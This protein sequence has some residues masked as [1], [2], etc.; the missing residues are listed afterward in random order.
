VSPSAAASPSSEPDD[1]QAS[2]NSG[3]AARANAGRARRTSAASAIA[4]SGGTATSAR[5][6]SASAELSYNAINPITTTMEAGGTSAHQRLLSRPMR[7]RRGSPGRA[8]TA[9]CASVR[10]QMETANDG[11]AHI[12]SGSGPRGR[13]AAS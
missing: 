5:T 13:E 2:A 7:S 8:M 4:A 12:V 10:K 11:I 6:E 9:A 3:T 1:P